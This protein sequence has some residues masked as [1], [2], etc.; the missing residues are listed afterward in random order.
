MT[1]ADMDRALYVERSL[2]KHL[3]MR[4]TLF[5]FP[6][7][8]MGFAQAGASNRVADNR[9]AQAHP[10]CRGDR[11][12]PERRA[13]AGPTPG[14]RCS[15]CSPTAGRQHRRSCAT[16]FPFCPRAR[17]HYGEGKSWGGR[18]AGRS[19]SVDHALRGGARRAGLERR[20]L[21]H[22][23]AALGLRRR[24]WLGEE[25]GGYPQQRAWHAWS[26]SGCAHSAPVR[27]ADIKWWLGSTVAGGAEGT[28]QPPGGR[29][30]S[31]R[32]DRAT[33]CPTTSEATH[34]GR[35]R[36]AALLPPLDPTTTGSWVRARLVPRADK[37][38][39]FDTSGNAGPTVWWDGRIVGGGARATAAR[40]SCR[41]SRTSTPKDWLTLEREAAD[42]TEWFGGTR[43]LP[44]FP[45]P[46]SRAQVGSA[47]RAPSGG[48]PTGDRG[49][50]ISALR[51]L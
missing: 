43:V 7:E 23:P 46:L 4:R 49:P 34:P 6:R 19:P 31:R 22:L 26:R 11:T 12:A 20:P 28:F 8:S 44:R 5:V 35:A 50:A 10:R 41:C 38:Q 36:W 39:L 42:L 16:R 13:L 27:K 14:S 18:D 3:A 30:R 1:V 2:V 45:S 15:L 33:C 17:S 29:G 25:I 37:A 24:C 40:S 48:F 21:E 32:A 9:A 51:H 47:R